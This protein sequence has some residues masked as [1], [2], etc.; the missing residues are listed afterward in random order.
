M[1]PPTAKEQLRFLTDLQRLLA[2]GQFVATY[3]Y[4]LLR[5]LTDIAVETGDDSGGPLEISTKQIAAKFITYYWRQCIP[6]IARTAPSKGRTLRQNTGKQASIIRLV[7]KARR[8]HGDSIAA[9][10]LDTSDWASMVHDV[11]QVVRRMP[12][13][14]LQTI[15]GTSFDFLYPNHGR[16]TS[17]ELRPGVAYCLRQFS[18]FIGQ[19]VRGGWTR[20][21]R[22]NNDELLETTADLS[23]FLFGS[24][25]SNLRAIREIFED[26]QSGLCFYCRRRLHKD[27]SQADHFIPW[28]RYPSD[29]GHNFVV[30]HRRCNSAK[31]DHLASVEYL[32]AWA[33]RNEAQGA[34]L[35]K[36][37]NERGILHDWPTS[38]HIAAW[39]YRQAF[40]GGGLTWQLDTE[41]VALSPEWERTISR[42]L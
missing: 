20:S 14:K 39:A 31:A 27:S 2:E 5:A 35:A 12:L 32:S 17:I 7:I 15:G 25:R 9:A 38:L 37:F 30:A 10:Q 23:E 28:S 13:W 11:D 6:Y 36:E 26:A 22:R 29:L 42:L 41:L 1:S 3:K 34:Q 21:I 8:R 16:G 18:E 33:E 4:A 19:M 24:D 40:Y